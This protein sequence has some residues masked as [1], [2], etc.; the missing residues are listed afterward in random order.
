MSI[1]DQVTITEVGMRDGFQ[2]EATSIPT[3]LK[4]NTLHG[5]IDS[6]VRRIQVTSFVHPKWVPQMADAE[7]VCAALPSTSGMT[8]TALALN[9]RGVVRANNAGITHIDLSISTNDQH[10]RDNANMSREDALDQA[11]E[12]VEL[13]QSY[14]MHIQMGFQCVFG[15]KKPGDTTTDLLISMIEPFLGAGLESISLA[16]STGMANPVLIKNVLTDVKSVSGSTPIVLHLH[17][18]RGLGL[19]NVCAALDCDVRHFDTSIGGLGG[20]PFIPGATGNIATEDTVYMLESMGLQ[21]GIDINQLSGVTSRIAE[22]VNRNLPGKL[23]KLTG[24][25]A[26]SV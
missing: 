6:G 15:Y 25:R 11:L 3:S 17:D 13:A 24:P 8:F 5:L 7:E 9:I 18:T 21:T 2:F 22:H 23:Y 19:A 10:S 1:S 20:C 16:D 12:M 4:I 14:G 26:L